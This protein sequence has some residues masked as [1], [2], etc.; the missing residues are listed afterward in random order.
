L[1][2]DEALRMAEDA[3]RR[4]SSVRASSVT[5]GSSAPAPAPPWWWAGLTLCTATESSRTSRVIST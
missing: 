3:D 4:L 1:I 5:S 2:R